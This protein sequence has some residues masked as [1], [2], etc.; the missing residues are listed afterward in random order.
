MNLKET[1]PGSRGEGCAN[2]YGGTTKVLNRGKTRGTKSTTTEQGASGTQQVARRHR[3]TCDSHIT[4]SQK[5][6]ESRGNS[7]T[8]DKGGEGRA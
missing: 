1:Y 5:E 3:K 8:L 4:H 7:E 2:D 6:I